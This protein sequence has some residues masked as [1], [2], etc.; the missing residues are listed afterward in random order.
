[1]VFINCRWAFFCGNA[2]G[3][4]SASF[5]TLFERIARNAMITKEVSPI[6]FDNEA[7]SRV[8][9]FSEDIVNQN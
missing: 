2:I 6:W 1:M 4:P 3:Q 8:L 9:K 7:C 5:G